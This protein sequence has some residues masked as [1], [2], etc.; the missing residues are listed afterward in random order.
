[1][2]RKTA[3]RLKVAAATATLTSLA[4]LRTASLG[5]KPILR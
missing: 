4:P 5:P 1:M 3:R 2:G